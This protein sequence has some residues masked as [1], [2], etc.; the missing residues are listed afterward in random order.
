LP[1]AIE[2]LASTLQMMQYE[3]VFGNLDNIINK[4]D[5]VF[6][7]AT[8]LHTNTMTNFGHPVYLEFGGEP[9]EECPV[10]MLDLNAAAGRQ[11]VAFWTDET[12]ANFIQLAIS[13]AGTLKVW[14]EPDVAT[15]QAQGATVALRDS[16]KWCIATRHA[17]NCLAYVKFQDPVKVSN[18]AVLYESLKKQADDWK[19]VYLELVNRIGTNRPYSKLPFQ[20]GVSDF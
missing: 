15:T 3:Q 7:D 8:G 10:G 14:Y 4:E 6:T 12:G 11:R 13:Q 20:A 5:I 2:Q 16:L 1:V 18:R 19:K 9:I 17:L